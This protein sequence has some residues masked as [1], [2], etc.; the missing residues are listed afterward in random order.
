L[1]L[2]T[3]VYTLSL[4]KLQLREK[5]FLPGCKGVGGRE[6][7]GG[8]KARLWGKGEEKTQILYAH[9]NKINK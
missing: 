6:G 2:L 5:H 9:M 8:R 4:T 7:K 3:I 1:V